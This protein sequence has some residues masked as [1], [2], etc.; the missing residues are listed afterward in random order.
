MNTTTARQKL[1]RRIAE[2]EREMD[3]RADCGQ[4]VAVGRLI[5]KAI[6][7]RHE[8]YSPAREPKDNTP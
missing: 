1:E 3:W 2:L 5:A 4:T 7:L 6:K 8:L